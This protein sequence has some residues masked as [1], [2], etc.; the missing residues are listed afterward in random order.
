[1]GNW[2]QWVA[3][4]ISGYSHPWDVRVVPAMACSGN[5]ISKANIPVV[6]R[7]VAAHAHPS[8]GFQSWPR[9][10]STR[11]IR[12]P[13]NLHSRLAFR[14]RHSFGNPHYSRKHTLLRARE[15]SLASYWSY[16]WQCVRFIQTLNAR[17]AQ[18]IYIYIYITKSLTDPTP[19]LLRIHWQQK[20]HTAVKLRLTRE[21]ACLKQKWLCRVAINLMVSN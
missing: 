6:A 15:C 18:R 11:S 9:C 5:P 19:Y 8:A 21:N 20:A 12:P 13:R 3:L 4:N 16:A 1:M 14:L 2:K 17:G 7:E 10:Q